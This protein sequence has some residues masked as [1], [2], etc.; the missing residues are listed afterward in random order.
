MV[1]TR[2]VAAVCLTVIA[3]ACGSRAAPLVTAPTLTSAEVARNYLNE[4]V[5]K[6]S[7]NSYKKQQIDWTAFRASVLQAGAGA[8][9]IAET[10][11]AILQALTLLA[12]GHSRYYPAAAGAAPLF[13]RTHTCRSSG[14]P[15]P[16]VPADIGYVRVTAFSGSGAAEVAFADSI[17]AQIQAAD[18]E[19]LSGWIVDL[20]GNGGGNMWPMLAGLGVIIGDGVVGHFIAPNGAAT[21][22]VIR[23][24][25][26]RAGNQLAVATSS[27]YTLR[28][29]A[30]RVAVLIDNGV[31]SS[32]EATFI[33]FR[34]RPNTRSFGAAT[35]GLSTAIATFPMSDSA[36]LLLADA[37]MADRN[38]VPFGDQIAPDE[39][40]ADVVND[41]VIQAINW[42]RAGS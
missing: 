29:A 19:G 28:H 35:C 3:I 13:F 11:P 1:L 17:Q 40:V 9:S 34:G 10:A 24:G 5:D 14:A 4:L 38:R 37:L 25:S 18:R 16:S 12:D 42:L 20:R 7:T 33:A 2:S 31:A 8:T 26:S 32:G 23:G 36:S 22:W 39:V 21:T 6:I 27:T 30:P 41:A 15:T